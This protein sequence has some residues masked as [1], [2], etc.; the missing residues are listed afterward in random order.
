MMRMRSASRKNLPNKTRKKKAN[1]VQ[2]KA[3]KENPNQQL[4]KALRMAK[5]EL[6]A[7]KMLQTPQAKTEKVVADLDRMEVKMAARMEDLKELMA[8]KVDRTE[9]LV[10]DSQTAWTRMI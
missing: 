5:E 3:R 10:L 8:R 2:K 9:G 1:Q 7:E 4:L 6:M